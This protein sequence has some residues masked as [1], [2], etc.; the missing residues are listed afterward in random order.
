M[1]TEN[2]QKEQTMDGEG[3]KEQELGKDANAII[4]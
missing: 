1:S 3:Q 4:S 2:H